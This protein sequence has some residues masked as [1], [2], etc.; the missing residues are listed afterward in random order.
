MF[1]SISII[2]YGM[3]CGGFSIGGNM[4]VDVGFR[5]LALF[6][7]VSFVEIWLSYVVRKWEVPVLWDCIAYVVI[8][9]LFNL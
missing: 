9:W 8:L 6:L 3:M 1:F 2:L 5:L 7:L 4:W